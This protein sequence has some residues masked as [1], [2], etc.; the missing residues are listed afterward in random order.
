MFTWTFS[1]G[2]PLLTSDIAFLFFHLVPLTSQQSLPVSNMV[3][4]S[5]HSPKGSGWLYIRSPYSPAEPGSP[6]MSD[7]A[8]CCLQNGLVL[9]QG[10]TQMD[11]GF[12]VH[13]GL[14]KYSPV[15][16]WA[17]RS[18]SEFSYRSS[19]CHWNCRQNSGTQKLWFPGWPPEG[20]HQSPRAGG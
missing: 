20:P 5:R 19:H 9:Y 6:R 12:Q 4:P 14:C 7:Y 3:E 15:G 10:D 2:R 8:P 13:P 18:S 11:Y 16:I 17:H 1:T